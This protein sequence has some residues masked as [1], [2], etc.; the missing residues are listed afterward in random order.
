MEPNDLELPY[1]YS[2]N[3]RAG[4][5][6]F[7]IVC[8]VA[9][10]AMLLAFFLGAPIPILVVFAPVGFAFFRA[11]LFDIVR[12]ATHEAI[13]AAQADGRLDEFIADGAFYARTHDMD[14]DDL[15]QRFHEIAEECK[16]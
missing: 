4:S 5:A 12:N 10:A 3:H 2:E 13:R 11:A 6:K 8:L 16:H 14:Q 7:L 9:T 15:K 1:P